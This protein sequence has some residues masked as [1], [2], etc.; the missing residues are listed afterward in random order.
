MLFTITKPL[1]Y[2]NRKTEKRHKRTGKKMKDKS[3]FTLFLVLDCLGIPPASH[4]TL[5]YKTTALQH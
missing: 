1:N 2:I 4:T 5:N 3:M